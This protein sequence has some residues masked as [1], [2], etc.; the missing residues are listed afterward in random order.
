M[1]ER[2]PSTVEPGGY[3]DLEKTSAGDLR[4]ILTTRGRENDAFTGVD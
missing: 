2:S 3:V 4:S 1:T